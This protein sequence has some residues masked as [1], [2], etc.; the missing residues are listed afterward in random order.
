MDCLLLLVLVKHRVNTTRRLIA[1]FSADAGDEGIA[2]D[3][4]FSGR[5]EEEVLLPDVG[6]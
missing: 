2:N 3:A 1:R 6:V 5:V 4:D